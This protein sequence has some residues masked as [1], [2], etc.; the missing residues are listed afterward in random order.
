MNPNCGAN[1]TGDTSS[2]NFDEYVEPNGINYYRLLPNY[3]YGSEEKHI[4]VQGYGYGN[5]QVCTS[6]QHPRPSQNVT[7]GDIK[8]EP[9]T[10]NQV[11]TFTL[12]DGCRDYDSV[13][14]CPPL[15]FSIKATTNESST[16]MC[17][18]KS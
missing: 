14:T 18:G 3:F 10:G 11:V 15:Y 6:R 4:K 9:V 7:Q 13:T 1:W 2:D 16:F 8:C 5:L 12:T 17:R